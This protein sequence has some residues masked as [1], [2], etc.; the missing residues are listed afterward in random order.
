MDTMGQ[1]RIYCSCHKRILWS[2]NVSSLVLQVASCLVHVKRFSQERV[3]ASLAAPCTAHPGLAQPQVLHDAWPPI[4]SC[5]EHTHTTFPA[6]SHSLDALL[7]QSQ[8]GLG[9]TATQ[10]QEPSGFSRIPQRRIGKSGLPQLE[11]GLPRQ[12]H[13]SLV[14]KNVSAHSLGTQH[15]RDSGIFNFTILFWCPSAVRYSSL[16]AA[17]SEPASQRVHCFVDNLLPLFYMQTYTHTCIH[18]YVH[19][20]THIQNFTMCVCIYI[21]E[22]QGRTPQTM[23]QWH[24]DYFKV[25]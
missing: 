18:L 25:T 9:R 19:T 5:L 10:L 16:P 12:P 22:V 2:S 4:C 20:N 24:I 6:S 11:T 7:E 15:G 23:S 13:V 21:V 14:F 17:T 8:I 3:S 1:L